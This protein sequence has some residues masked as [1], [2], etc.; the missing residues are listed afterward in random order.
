MSIRA[1]CHISSP[2]KSRPGSNFNMVQ[3]TYNHLSKRSREKDPSQSNKTMPL[4]FRV[5]SQS[6]MMNTALDPGF[7]R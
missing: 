4:S 3:N 1:E 6:M 5:L 2:L 7:L